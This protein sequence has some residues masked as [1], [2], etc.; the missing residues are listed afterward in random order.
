MAKVKKRLAVPDCIGPNALK[1][2]R[3]DDYETPDVPWRTDTAIQAATAAARGSMLD[4][5][6]RQQTTRNKK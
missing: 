5:T 6:V 2:V 4:T 3:S 1:V